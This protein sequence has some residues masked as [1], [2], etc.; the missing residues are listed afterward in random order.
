MEG[1]QEFMMVLES[2]TDP[3]GDHDMASSVLCASSGAVMWH[4][5]SQR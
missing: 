5:G 2:S 3:E 4:H 1:N